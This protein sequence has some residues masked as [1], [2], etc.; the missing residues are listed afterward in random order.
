MSSLLGPTALLFKSKHFFALNKPAGVHWDEVM[1]QGA[2]D[3]E[4][5]HRLDHGTSGVLL[6]SHKDQAEELR[7]ALFQNPLALKK[8]YLAGA[9][10]PLLESQL[11]GNIL[12]F[13]AQRYKGS[14]KVSFS[15]LE[16]DLL[17]LRSLRSCVHSVRKA[18]PI[19]NCPFQG[20]LYEVILVTGARHQ[21]RSYF[22]YEE[23]PLIGDSLYG[24]PPNP[25]I[26]LHAWKL[27]FQCPFEKIDIE[28][29]APF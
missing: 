28:I 18:T 16:E 15:T 22:A 27:Q 1:T 13:T 8:S 20:H 11:S 9:S 3:W 17:G 19:A 6:Y 10:A 21:I 2:S 25:R 14:K 5:L 23:A 4:P 24:G 12:G 7:K 29:E 26:E